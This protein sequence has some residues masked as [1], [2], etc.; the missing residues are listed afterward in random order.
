[1]RPTDWETTA[2]KKVVYYTHRSQEMGL[3]GA[4]RGGAGV[5]HEAGGERGTVGMSLYYGFRKK[6]W[7]KQGKQV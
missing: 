1:M 4:T 5:D 2:I 7:A 6:E 3:W